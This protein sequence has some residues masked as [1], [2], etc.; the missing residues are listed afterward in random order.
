MKLL[1]NELQL[2]HPVIWNIEKVITE[3]I[4]RADITLDPFSVT[5]G[6]PAPRTAEE[7]PT[8]VHLQRA[9]NDLNLR[10]FIS[11]W[12]RRAGRVL[13]RSNVDVDDGGA[14]GGGNAPPSATAARFDALEARLD[15][16]AAEMRALAADTQRGFAG[17]I[18][19]FTTGL[20]NL[21]S[22]LQL[23]AAS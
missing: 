21:N 10:S 19:Q 20:A 8:P 1:S 22:T 18:S 9:V 11:T 4:A 6:T 13:P 16:D 12:S 2:E 5:D 14:D 3:A 7:N 15:T 17:M 23:Q